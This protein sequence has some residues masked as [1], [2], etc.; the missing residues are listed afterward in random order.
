MGNHSAWGCVSME[1]FF[2]TEHWTQTRHVWKHVCMC[3]T[4]QEVSHRPAL[5]TVQGSVDSAA[6][7]NTT[8]GG[9]KVKEWSEKE[10][11]ESWVLDGLPS[12]TTFIHLEPDYSW[13]LW[14]QH[15]TVR[16]WG[17]SKHNRNL[18]YIR[19]FLNHMQRRNSWGPLF[20]RRIVPRVMHMDCT[21]PS[22][23]EC[24]ED[25]ALSADQN[26]IFRPR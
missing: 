1:V 10:C 15:N 16:Q 24:T 5:V 13:F 11:K 22:A 20:V 8:E 12:E 7:L 14:R 21:S 2:P 17:D 9:K 19:G 3:R 26:C 4:W 23:T 25:S 6:D 18:N